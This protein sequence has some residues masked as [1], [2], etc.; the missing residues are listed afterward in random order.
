MLA[1]KLMGSLS[2]TLVRQYY[3]SSNSFTIP[4]G[5]TSLASLSIRGGTGTNGFWGSTQDLQLSTMIGNYP[6]STTFDSITAAAQ[7]EWDKFP[8][9]YTPNGSLV[10]Y[11]L[12]SYFYSGLTTTNVS[13]RYCRV[14]SGLTKTKVG[15]G[16]SMTGSYKLGDWPINTNWQWRVG[17][18]QTYVNPVTGDTTTAFGYTASGGSPGNT[19]QVINALNVP[20]TPGQ[21]YNLSIGSGGYVEF[22]Y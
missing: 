17:N 20:V 13:A 19:G 14:A 7:T 21:S 11:D 5:I 4:A 16:W 8:S 15:N 6:T 3:T 9:S 22:Y 10:S 18:I 1:Q 12:R 2:K